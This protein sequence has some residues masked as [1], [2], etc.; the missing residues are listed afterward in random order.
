MIDT[1]PMNRS[2]LFMLHALAGRCLFDLRWK[3]GIIK[4]SKPTRNGV[5]T[6]LPDG[7]LFYIGPTEGHTES[8][9]APLE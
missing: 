9:D 2:Y 8:N 6:H 1:A 3:L 4:K 7:E 5:I